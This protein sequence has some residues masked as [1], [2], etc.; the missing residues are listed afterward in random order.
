[1]VFHALQIKEGSLPVF[2]FGQCFPLE[3]C[4]VCELWFGRLLLSMLYRWGR[5]RPPSEVLI[6]PLRPSFLFSF[7]SSSIQS[8]SCN[9]SRLDHGWSHGDDSRHGMNRS[10]RYVK[11]SQ[12][13]DQSHSHRPSSSRSCQQTRAAGGKVQS[14]AQRIETLEARERCL[15]CLLG[16]L[17]ESMRNI[18]D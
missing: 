14:Q 18:R 2:D 8:V 11:T 10:Q 12:S 5:D 1:M 16:D 17:A 4:L 7:P 6:L 3:T 13:V 9:S 15:I